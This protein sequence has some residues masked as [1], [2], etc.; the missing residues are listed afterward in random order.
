MK[1]YTVTLLSALADIQIKVWM[2]SESRKINQERPR[3]LHHPEKNCEPGGPK[4]IFTH[5]LKSTY[6]LTLSEDTSF[7][8]RQITTVT[9]N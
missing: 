2:Y 3:L 5:L 1:Y 4:G 8:T 7:V 6:C 9:P